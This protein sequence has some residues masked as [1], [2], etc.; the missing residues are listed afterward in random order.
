MGKIYTIDEIRERVKPVAEKYG[1]DKVT[2]FGSYARGEATEE[3]DVDLMMAYK[4]LKGSFA[5]GGVYAD[6]QEALD[7]SLDLVSECA[8]TAD[9]ANSLSKKL[10]ANIKREG[11]SLYVKQD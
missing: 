9:Y 11:I 5:L 7:K 8:L 10:Y 2:L 6:F 4:D 3:S 1:L